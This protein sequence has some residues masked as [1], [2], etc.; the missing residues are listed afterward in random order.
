MGIF[1][2]IICFLHLFYSSHLFL[3]DSGLVVIPLC[4]RPFGVDSGICHP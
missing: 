1:I 4:C 2:F 3:L